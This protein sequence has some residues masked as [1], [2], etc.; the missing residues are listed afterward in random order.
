MILEQ[1]L[2]KLTCKD[3]HDLHYSES[4]VFGDDEKVEWEIY[5]YTEDDCIVL[6]DLDGNEIVQ[7]LF[8][9]TGDEE[10]SDI[11]YEILNEELFDHYMSP[12]AWI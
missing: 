11:T 6:N 10:T 8:D 12:Q 3:L 7:I 4:I 1:V 5:H 2:N 9:Y